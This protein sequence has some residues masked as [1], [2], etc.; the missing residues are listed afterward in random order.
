MPSAAVEVLLTGNSHLHDLIRITH[1]HRNYNLLPAFCPSNI[2]TFKPPLPSSNADI[3]CLLLPPSSPCL[4]CHGNPISLP[5][6]SPILST[7]A[8]GRCL[9]F[10]PGSYRTW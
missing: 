2:R 10:H 4:L 6:P 8:T 5:D 3:P 9:V 7:N 1:S